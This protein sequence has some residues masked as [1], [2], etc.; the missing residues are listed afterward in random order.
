MSCAEREKAAAENNDALS[1]PC[2]DIVREAG[3]I[4]GRGLTIDQLAAV[5][6]RVAGA[7]VVNK[8]GLSGFFSWDLYF[9]AENRNSPYK[10]TPPELAAAIERQLGLRLVPEP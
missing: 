9:A 6:T 1:H 2:G 10:P 8:T 4:E 3:T 7:T 5:L